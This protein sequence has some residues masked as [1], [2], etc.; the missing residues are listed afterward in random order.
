LISN[1]NTGI[2]SKEYHLVTA[3]QTFLMQNDKM[4]SKSMSYTP[5][6]LAVIL[7]LG[8]T[9][10]SSSQAQKTALGPAQMMAVAD[11]SAK[12]TNPNTQSPST[13]PANAE[14]LDLLSLYREAAFNDPV[15]NAAKYGFM[16]GKEKRWQGLSVLLPQVVG[17]GNE[18]KND[19]YNQ[20]TGNRRN[21]L[22]SRAWNVRLT[23]PLFNWD[24]FEQ[25]R[26]G[27]LNADIAE[28]QYAAAEQDLVIRVTEAY[29]NLLNTEDTLNLARNKKILIGEQ[30]EQ[31]K[32]NFEVGTST[33]TDTHEAQSRYD[34]VVA[35]ELA[36]EA[37]L[38]IKRGALEQITGKQIAQIKSLSNTAKIDAVAKDRKVKL[39]KGEKPSKVNVEN[40]L[41]VI[42]GQTMQDW[43]RQAE[44]VSYNIIASKLSYDVATKETKRAYAG[45]APSVDFVAQRGY[46]DNESTVPQDGTP[47]SSKSYS[48]QA[49]IQL[50]VPLFSGGYNQSVVREKSAL[51][52]KALADLE[53]TR[54]SVAQTTRQAYL[55]FNNGLAQVKAYEAAEL[56]ALSA[57][58]SNKLGYEVGVRINIDVLNAQ[59]TLFT[60]RRD[61]AKARYDTILNGLKLKAQA[62]VLSDEDLQAV[63]ALLK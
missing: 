62:A 17:T 33:I 44:D 47:F 52:N 58:E 8:S 43:V 35:Q 7:A 40:A 14:A 29:F 23:Q 21:D 63:N 1:I 55:G 18:T 38:L 60:T 25:A 61:L 56:S 26:Q 12:P 20:R 51:A 48:T 42:P 4:R 57:L 53:N 45:H 2:Y 30:L 22:M 32:R 15:F 11:T 13:A 36:A 3:N 9:W 10:S 49:T 28:A 39:K 37:D 41:A 46:A 24:K 19:I 6:A 16:A 5:I 54:R 31:A 34:L 50:T 27:D 59:D